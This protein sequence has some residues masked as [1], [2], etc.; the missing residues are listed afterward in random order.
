[1]QIIY[2]CGRVV[3]LGSDPGRSTV[4]VIILQ[5]LGHVNEKTVQCVE[6]SD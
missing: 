3:A 2:R 6:I 4:F 1:M 5:F